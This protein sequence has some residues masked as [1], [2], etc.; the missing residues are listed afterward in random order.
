M[1]RTCIIFR[2]ACEQS[3][4]A[5]YILR[6]LSCNCIGAA[7]SSNTMWMGTSSDELYNKFIKG[8]S[9]EFS[10][11][12]LTEQKKRKRKMVR[13]MFEFESKAS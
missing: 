8:A 5:K 12:A 10:Y 2:Y 6:Y 9:T 4:Y 7:F 1:C 13:E 11:L 3:S